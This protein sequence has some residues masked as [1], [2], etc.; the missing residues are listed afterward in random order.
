[1]ISESDV[2]FYT[3]NGYLVVP[4]V[5]DGETITALRR[6]V[7]ELVSASSAVTENNELYDLEA[8][9]RRDAPRVRRL[10]SPDQHHAAF[11]ALQDGGQSFL[12][13]TRVCQRSLNITHVSVLTSACQ[14][15]A[16]KPHC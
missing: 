10:K 8:D 12:L 4:Q 16:R 14:A 1:M 13:S 2:E 3:T 11:A 5:L 9:H 6:A 7:D 15:C